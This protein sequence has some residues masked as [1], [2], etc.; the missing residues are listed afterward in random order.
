MGTLSL[1]LL[2]MC[3]VWHQVQRERSHCLTRHVSVTFNLR[4]H[5]PTVGLEVIIYTEQQKKRIFCF[6]GIVYKLGVKY[7]SN[8]M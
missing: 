5:S 2:V 4:V 6:F 8:D 3:I 1:S 7:T